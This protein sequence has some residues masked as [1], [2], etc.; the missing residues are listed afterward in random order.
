MP[1]L[2]RMHASEMADISHAAAG[3]IVAMFG[4]E[5]ASGDTFTDGTVRWAPASDMPHPCKLAAVAGFG[6][7]CTPECP[8]QCI[9]CQSSPV[10]RKLTGLQ[11]PLCSPCSCSRFRFHARA[12][13]AGA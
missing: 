7:M 13:T 2:V 3:D 12:C 6:A 9:A 10:H 5:C 11:R 8:M 1:R 4:I